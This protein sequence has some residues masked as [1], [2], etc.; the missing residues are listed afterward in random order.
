MTSAVEV[1]P[2][3]LAVCVN[4]LASAVFVAVFAGLDVWLWVRVCGRLIEPVLPV[5]V[6]S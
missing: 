5:C 6:G 4:P 1:A 2:P 3:P